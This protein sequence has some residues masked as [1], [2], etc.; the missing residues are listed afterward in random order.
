VSGARNANAP[1]LVFVMGQLGEPYQTLV[2]CGAKVEAKAKGANLKVVGPAQFDPTL[3]IPVLN[4]A[5]ADHPAAVLIIPTDPVALYAPLKQAVARGTKVILVNIGLKNEDI[6]SSAIVGADYKEG[7]ISADLLAKQVGYK[8]KVALITFTPGQSTVTDNRWHGFEAEMKK[9][10]A[11]HPGLDYVGAQATIHNPTDG[12]AVFSALLSKYPDLAGVTT[13][14]TFATDAVATGISERHVAGKVKMVGFDPS[15]AA[16]ADVQQ[17]IIQV[18][19]AGQ[20]RQQGQLSVDEA[21][22][23][24]QGKTVPKTVP[25][26]FTAITKADLNTPAMQALI[27]KPPAPG[28]C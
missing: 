8:G 7:G 12:A 24:I 4:A 18:L 17:G 16:A 2:A 6:A 3:Q 21:L 27:Y 28:T 14:F 20:P 11:A 13:T 1:N 25:S 15:P 19:I 5:L 22:D 23:A 10:V 9:L 26:G